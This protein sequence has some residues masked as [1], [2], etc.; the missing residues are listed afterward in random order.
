MTTMD[1]GNAVF[2]GA[3]NC[4]MYYIY[5][6]V[7]GF[8]ILRRSNSCIHAVVR[9]DFLALMYRMYCMLVLQ[10]QKPATK[11]SLFLDTP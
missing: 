6:P 4:L 8:G 5:I 7:L 9:S 11:T 3:K 1:G 2:A 10:E